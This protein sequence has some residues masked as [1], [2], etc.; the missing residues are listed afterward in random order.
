VSYAATTKRRAGLGADAAY[1]WH[2]YS[3]ETLTLQKTINDALRARGL[4]TLTED[5]KLGATTCGASRSLIGQAPSTCTTFT[6]PKGP[7][8]DGGTAPSVSAPV[9]LPSPATMQAAS[10]QFGTS[11]DWTKYAAFA[12]GALVVVGGLYYFTHRKGQS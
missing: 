8:C 10:M 7:P 9:A 11:I 6:E 5:G 4:C 12:A 3:A 1:P 2:A